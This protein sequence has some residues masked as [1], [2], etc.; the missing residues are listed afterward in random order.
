MAD[1]HLLA[2]YIGCL[3]ISRG[4]PLGYQRWAIKELAYLD[5]LLVERPHL[6]LAVQF[7]KEAL[8]GA[9]IHWPEAGPN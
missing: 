3:I 5:V 4:Y 7:F 1:E 2:R 9:G 6:H 8:D